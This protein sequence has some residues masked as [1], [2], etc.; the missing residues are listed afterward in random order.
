MRN[1]IC[2][3]IALFISVSTLGYS[4]VFSKEVLNAKI[5]QNKLFG[6]SLKIPVYSSKVWGFTNSGVY[7]EKKNGKWGL[8]NSN[9][10][11]L[12]MPYELDS[13]M[14]VFHFPNIKSY[15][16]KKD[17]KWRSVAFDEKY[18]I[19]KS[20][21][22]TG[23]THKAYKEYGYEIKND[24]WRRF[25]V[26]FNGKQGV[27]NKAYATIIPVKYDYILDLV[28]Y[29]SE[30][31]K[32]EMSYV[33]YNNSKAG[34]I[35]NDLVIE[36]KF[37]DI[38]LYYPTFTGDFGKMKRSYKTDDLGCKK[39][40]DDKDYFGIVLNGK[41]GVMSFN[42]EMIV[43]AIY[44]KM[45][46]NEVYLDDNRNTGTFIVK[47]D[48]KYGVINVTNKELV[49]IKYDMVE[50]RDREGGLDYFTVR[51]KDKYGIV[52]SLNEFVKPVE[53]TRKSLED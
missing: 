29:L 14:T 52:N 20:E 40:L 18:K 21:P 36:P 9:K 34:L 26:V 13:V 5:E 46:Y 12:M 16:I 11:K 47:K 22:D 45:Y 50:Y 23:L 6:D 39:I 15:I 48:G 49:S 27:M 37:D 19:Q 41:C 1:K 25:P 44:D 24:D 33:V 31:A 38:G 30:D 43:P 8:F 28:T 3:L 10:N 53:F 51:I 35:T 4:Q 2:Y 42:Q 7:F 32:G 17:G